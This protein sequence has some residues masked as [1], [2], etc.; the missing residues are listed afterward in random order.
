MA[1]TFDKDLALADVYAAALFDLA[2][3]D[4][5]V[6]AVRAELEGLVRLQ[7]DDPQLAAFLSSAAI[8][9]DERARS[10]ERMFRG[11]LSDRVLNT[12]QV[13]NRHGRIALLPALLRA[14]VI[15]TEHA[16]GQ[17][18]VV[19]TS[20]AEL[21]GPQKAEIEAVARA[22]SGRTP[23][24]EYVVDPDILGGLIL[25][26]GDVRYDNSLRHHLQAARARLLERTVAGATPAG[27]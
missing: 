10:L 9:H 1:E 25:Q 26:V 11:R 13:M 4:Q 17:I 23:L 15:R 27:A 19:A 20:A 5:T 12:L 21:D 2:V 7:A 6:D 22:L 8:D 18:E 24:I 3:A 14:F 16:R